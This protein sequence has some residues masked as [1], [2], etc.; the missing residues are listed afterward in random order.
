[1]KK[2]TTTV[3]TPALTTKASTSP[4][5]AKQASEAVVK[6]AVKETSSTTPVIKAQPE[7]AVTIAEKTPETTAAKTTKA[8]AKPKPVKKAPVVNTEPV[9]SVPAITM[10]DR[11][12]LTAGAIWHYLA[13][14]GSTS[15]VKLVNAIPEQE[16]VIQ[17]SIG[18]LAME[19]KITF[20]VVDYLEVIV[21]KD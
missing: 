11:I 21:L 8:S 20:A 15:V 16:D 13:E 7:V 10:H 3:K 5:A 6:T 18:W 2:N 19:G 14:Q 1:M 9:A 12:G 17:R 4:K